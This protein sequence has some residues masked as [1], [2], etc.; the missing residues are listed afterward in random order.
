MGADNLW[1][2]KYIVHSRKPKEFS[3]KCTVPGCTRSWYC[4]G[5]KAGFV[6][7]AA[8]SHCRAHWRKFHE[9]QKHPEAY[10]IDSDGHKHFGQEFCQICKDISNAEY[11]KK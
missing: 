8:Q 9:E 5:T 1:A 3:V 2:Y 7:A 4:T 11:F 6:F 10:W